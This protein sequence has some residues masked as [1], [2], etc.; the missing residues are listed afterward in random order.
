MKDTPLIV[1]SDRSLLLDVHHRDS[2][3]CRGDLIRFCELVKSPEHMHTYT[4]TALSLYNASALG[5]TVDAIMATLEKWSRFPIADSVRFFVQDM[6]SRWGKVTLTESDDPTYYTLHVESER[7]RK[8]LM[9]RTA[10]AKLLRTRDETSFLIQA[11]HRGEVKLQLIKAGWPVDD[12]IPLSGGEKIDISLLPTTRAGLPFDVR[13]YQ[14]NA[15]NALLGDMGPGSGYGVIVMPCGSGKTVVGMKIMERIA[16]RTLIVTTNV[17]AVRQWKAE[18]LDKSSLTEAEIGEYSG[19]RKEVRDVTICTYQVLTWRK[20]KEGPFLHLDLLTQGGWGLVIYDEVHMLPAPIFKVTAELQAI[21][22]LGL[23]ATL[24]REDGREEEVFSL[25]GPKRFDVPWSELEQ[26]GFIATAYCHEIRIE[27]PQELEIPYAIATKRQKYRIAS[28]NPRKLEVIQALI[29]H[30]P[31]D[32]IL[33]IGQYLDQLEEI[34]K[35]LDAPLITGSTPNSRRDE[36][37][38]AFREGLI[39]ILVVSKVANFAIDLP[40]ASV[41]IQVSGSFGSRSEEAQRLGR[42]LRPKNRSSFFYSIITQYSSEEE[43]GANRQKFLAEQ[44]YTYEVEVWPN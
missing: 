14:Q 8:E 24:V 15:A 26:Q 39:R 16:M 2:E 11:Y 33:V 38:N 32:F 44:G 42:I 41:A 35:L 4:I 23:T 43:F 29:E 34:S 27:L 22:R 6:A 1:Q 9:Q 25:V 19:D 10:I 7:I 20:E 21:H 30:H 40:D 3:A 36:L 28:E 12:R 13:P 31:D 37:Y 5:L 17:A 18:L